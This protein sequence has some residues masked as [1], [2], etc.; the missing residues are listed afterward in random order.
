MDWVTISRSGYFGDKRDELIKKYNDK[1]REGDWR[2][3]WLWNEKALT[4]EQ[5][6]LIYEDAY[7]ADSFR[8]EDLWMKLASIAKDVYDIEERDIESG[9]DYLIQKGPAT[10]LQDISIRR[11]VLR[12]G[13][14][15]EGDKLVKIRNHKFYWGEQLSPGRVPFHLPEKIVEPHIEGWWDSNSIEDFYQSNKVLQIKEALYFLRES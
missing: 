2:I 6:Y 4:K 15:F 9:L 3:A 8:R 5:A 12:R 13:W 10:H 14:E 1:Y 7:Y 11:V